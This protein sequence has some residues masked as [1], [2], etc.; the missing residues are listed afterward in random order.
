LVNF[1]VTKI[2]QSQLNRLEKPSH[3]GAIP[4]ASSRLGVSALGLACG[5]PVALD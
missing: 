1:R 5:R 4:L 2:N 3:S